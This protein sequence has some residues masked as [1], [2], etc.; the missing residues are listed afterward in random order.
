MLRF[1]QFFRNLFK[2][3]PLL[4]VTYDS[5]GR[6][7]PTI[8]LVHGIAATSKTWDLL[9]KELGTKKYRI[10]AVDILGFG[11][12]PKPTGCEYTVDDHTASLYRTIRKMKVRKPFKLVGHSMGAIVVAHYGYLFSDEVSQLYLLSP[13]IYLPKSDIQ[14]KFLQTR[15]DLYLN[16]YKFLSENKKFT[17][18]NSQII[19]KLLRITDGVDVNEE[20]WDSFRL[21]LINTIVNQDVF[22]DIINIKIPIEVVF[23]NMDEFIIQEIVKKLEEFKHVRI[24]KLSNV[25]HVVGIKYAK[26]VVKIINN[27]SIES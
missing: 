3:S 19:R 22:R 8:I 7:K 13:P 2:L 17:I 9:I 12:S 27:L 23:G 4:S 10:I 15:T 26:E 21:S 20:N 25:D 14:N 1:F 24:T 5:G 18:D 11:Q 6:K 16:A